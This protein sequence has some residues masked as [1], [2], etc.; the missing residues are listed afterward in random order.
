M[1]TENQIVKEALTALAQ[2]RRDI[3]D[4]LRVEINAFRAEVA[5]LKGAQDELIAIVGTH[6]NVHTWEQALECVR[7]VFAQDA[8]HRFVQH[9]NAQPR[10]A[11]SLSDAFAQ[12]DALENRLT[13]L[14]IEHETEAEHVDQR[15]DALEH[16][17]RGE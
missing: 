5:A 7:L 3:A 17:R 11:G 15:L 12:F 6:A 13:R 14:E 8:A 10:R 16:P 1:S 2:R 9:E 4:A